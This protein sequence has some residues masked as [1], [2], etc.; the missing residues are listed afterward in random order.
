M[1]PTSALT[2][3]SLSISLLDGV[4]A[5]GE[6]VSGQLAV[7]LPSKAVI[8]DLVVEIIGEQA[9]RWDDWRD[10]HDISVPKSVSQVIYTTTHAVTQGPLQ[11]GAGHHVFPF[12]IPLATRLEESLH[13][14]VPRTEDVEDVL[15]T[16][17]YRAEARAT[18][19]RSRASMLNAITHFQVLPVERTLAIEE[20]AAMC[21]SSSTSLAWLGLV[22]R[23]SRRLTVALRSSVI[24]IDGALHLQYTVDNLRAQVEARSVCF[25]LHED[26]SFWLDAAQA[27]GR[28]MQGSRVVWHRH[29]E[30]VAAGE[31]VKQ[32][33]SIPTVS[34]GAEISVSS[35]STLASQLTIRHRLT[36]SCSTPLYSSLVI[37]IPL[38]IVRTHPCTQTIAHAA[39]IHSDSIAS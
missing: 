12:A 33:V 1:S 4:Y 25:T 24:D 31:L 29:F 10:L 32:E 23:G 37:E 28:M 27:D 5:P 30:G 13:H 8:T 36:V 35:S 7:A 15:F 6:I 21:C 38:T 11:L 14:Q 19:H 16:V 3:R 9:V 18:F 34:P 39:T 2:L 22:S 17:S 26:T 20:E